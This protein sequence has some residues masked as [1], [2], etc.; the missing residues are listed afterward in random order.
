MEVFAD[1]KRL[2]KVPRDR[3]VGE[4]KVLDIVKYRPTSAGITRSRRACQ[5]VRRKERTIKRKAGGS[6]GLGRR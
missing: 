6:N 4:K 2:Q 5:N 3:L 1:S